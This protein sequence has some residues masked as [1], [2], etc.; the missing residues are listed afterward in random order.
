VLL[1]A[2]L[3]RT[4]ALAGARLAAATLERALGR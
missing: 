3:D 2:D 4:R 1:Q